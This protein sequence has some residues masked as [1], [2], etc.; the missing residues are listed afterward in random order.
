[1]PPPHLHPRSSYTTSL[2]TTT[3]ALSFLIVGLPHVLPCP[4]PR[5]MFADESR[6]DPPSNRQK[7]QMSTATDD[8]EGS[9]GDRIHEGAK[10]CEHESG[11][12]QARI[13]SEETQRLQA[14]AHECPVPKPSGRLGQLLGFTP[15]ADGSKEG[16]GLS[17]SSPRSR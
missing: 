6:S 9:V 11:R 14:K 5:V 4:A 17:G 10:H 8:V 3:L 16:T 7:H 13:G 15:S 2:F 12:A 1:M